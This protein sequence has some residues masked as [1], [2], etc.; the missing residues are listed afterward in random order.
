VKKAEIQPANKDCSV[1]IVRPPKLSVAENEV[2][3]CR[4]VD[5]KLRV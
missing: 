5:D 2:L 1:G 4:L 3:H